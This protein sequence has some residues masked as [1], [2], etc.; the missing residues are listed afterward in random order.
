MNGWINVHKKCIN[1]CFRKL[2]IGVPEKHAQRYPENSWSYSISTI[3]LLITHDFWLLSELTTIDPTVFSSVM[4]VF[5]G[6]GICTSHF[7]LSLD[8]IHVFKSSKC[9]G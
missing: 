8:P 4:E 7:W 6:A 2:C 9:S 5:A 3:E 1:I